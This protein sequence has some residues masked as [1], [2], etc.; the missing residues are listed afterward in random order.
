MVQKFY[1]E[2]DLMAGVII[3]RNE[4]KKSYEFSKSIAEFIQKKEGKALTSK[5]LID[6]ILEKYGEKIQTPYLTFLINIVQNYFKVKVPKISGV[7]D[8]L[9]FL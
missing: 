5:L 7:K 2:Y 4:I 8:L 6:Y 9:G 1:S 3:L